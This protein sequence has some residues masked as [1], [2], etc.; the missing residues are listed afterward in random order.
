MKKL[1][2]TLIFLI[3]AFSA[4]SNDSITKALALRFAEIWHF[5]PQEKVYLHTD[6]PYYSAGE[7]LWFSAYLINATTHLSNTKSRYIYVELLD[8]GDSVVTRAKIKIDSIGFKGHINLSPEM[9]AGIYNLRAYTYWM[10]NAHRDFFYAKQIY[11]GNDI[12]DRVK[13]QSEFGTL[14]KKELPVT[15]TFTNVFNSPIVR[16]KVLIT[17]NWGK[18][19]TRTFLSDEN[20]KVRLTLKMNE[21]INDKKLLQVQIKQEGFNFDQKILLPEPEPDFDIQFM[22]ESGVFLD[23][24]IQNLA[25]KAIGTNGFGVDVKGKI[26]NQNDE[27]ITEFTS[28]NKG[29]GRIVFKTNPD[30]TY[31]AMVETATGIQK[32]FD[33]PKPQKM[34]IALHLSYNRGRIFFQ[35]INETDILPDSLFLLIHSR[36]MLLS[37]IPFQ[38]EGSLSESLLPAGINAFSVVDISGNV[39]CERLYFSRNFQFPNITMTANKKS[40][41]KREAVSLDFQILDANNKPVEGRFSISVT[42]SKNVIADTLHTNIVNYFLLTSDLQGYVEEPNLY[43]ADNSNSTREKTDILLLTQGWRRFNTEDILKKKYP[44]NE[45]YLEAGQAITGKVF[46]IL[47]KPAKNRQVIMFSNK[48]VA[49]TETDENGRFLIDGIEFPDSTQMVLKAKSS[50]KILDVEL[51]CDKDHFPVPEVNLPFR[52]PIKI[53]PPKDYFQIIKNKYY[54]EGGLLLI[55][56]EEITVRGQKRRD[57]QEEYYTSTADITISSE[58]I[59]EM[60]GMTVFDLLSTIA[61]VQVNGQEITI[62]NEKP[63]FV[64]DGIEIDSDRIDDVYYLNTTDIQSIHI[65]KGVSTLAITARAGS[66]IVITL[67]RGQMYSKPQ[68]ISLMHIMPLGFQKPEQFYVPRYDVDS[69]YRQPM[70]DLRTTIYWNPGLVTDATGKINVKFYTADKANDYDVI[71]EGIGKA[72]EICRFKGGMKRY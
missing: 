51:V 26:F 33:L 18:G 6:K 9:P 23:N 44:K 3:S 55:N 69:I 10:Q 54:T 2:F 15:L 40:Y 61:G 17:Q 70:S 35:L 52:D 38:S 68:A 29:M 66:A 57:S 14:N 53:E 34:G 7:T 11:I 16:Q 46:N 13:C 21:I 45:F 31:Y 36:G 64:I 24:H 63:L 59:E 32:R 19:E 39:Y 58:R 4:F 30:E 49:V 47:N 50:T 42:D 22:P 71:I 60:A 8:I 65:Y 25:F 5:A 20:G 12:D 67:K 28:V 62:R 1:I 43:F 37:A 72:G 41:N 48:G 56:L 27:E